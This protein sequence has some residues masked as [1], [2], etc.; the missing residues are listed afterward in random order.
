MIKLH[1][2]NKSI[3]LI[4]FLIIVLV[5]FIVAAKFH[6]HRVNFK[7]QRMCVIPT[8]HIA[9]TI[10]KQMKIETNKKITFQ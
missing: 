8:K 6:F 10:F 5:I 3:V 2:R 7:I 1:H 4:I 9:Q